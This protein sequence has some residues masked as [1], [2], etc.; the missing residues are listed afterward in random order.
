[1][2]GCIRHTRTC[3]SVLCPAWFSWQRPWLLAHPH[4]AEALKRS[5]SLLG[6]P[7]FLGICT[8]CWEDS[9]HVGSSWTFGG[10][11]SCGCVRHSTRLTIHV[12]TETE[13]WAEG[14]WKGCLLP[15][16]SLSMQWAMSFSATVLTTSVPGH[17]DAQRC[18]NFSKSKHWYLFISAEMADLPKKEMQQVDCL[19]IVQEELSRGN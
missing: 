19:L 15:K 10:L 3:C 5:S 16:I 7:T 1:M 6:S 8:R 4:L 9:S 13:S 18:L 17:G 11:E 14:K 2:F 12:C